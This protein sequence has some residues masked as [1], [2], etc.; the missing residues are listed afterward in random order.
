MREVSLQRQ[1]TLQDHYHPGSSA[2]TMQFQTVQKS[3]STVESAMEDKNTILT[4]M[5]GNT[6]EYPSTGGHIH[7]VGNILHNSFPRDERD[8]YSLIPTNQGQSHHSH[9]SQELPGN[10]RIFPR[11]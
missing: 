3:N 11:R 10:N 2:A 5:L 7:P 9:A 6:Y 4:P 1:H 8:E